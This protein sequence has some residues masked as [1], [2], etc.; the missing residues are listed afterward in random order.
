LALNAIEEKYDLKEKLS[1]V[2]LTSINEGLADIAQGRAVSNEEVEALFK[3]DLE[4]Y[5]AD[6]DGK[7]AFQDAA[8]LVAQLSGTE[9]GSVADVVFVLLDRPRFDILP[10]PDD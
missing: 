1:E 10:P 8:A 2:G 6:A 7:D 5:D 9:Q 4:D 3:D